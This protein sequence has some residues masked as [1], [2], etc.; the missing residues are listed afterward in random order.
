MSGKYSLQALVIKRLCYI[1]GNMHPTRLLYS[2]LPVLVSGAVAA[3]LDFDQQPLGVVE[4][5][6]GSDFK[7]VADKKAEISKVRARSGK[8]SLRLLGGEKNRVEIHLDK[9]AAANTAISFWAERWTAKASFG[10]SIYAVDAEG[11][12]Q[13][14]Y[15]GGK[16]IKAGGLNTQVSVLIPQATTKLVLE[17]SSPANAGM[18][19][20]DL[21]IAEAVP[22]QIEQL[23]ASQQVVPAL[24]R[25]EHNP[26]AALAVTSSKGSVAA[27]LE[28]LEINLTGTTSLEDI[29]SVSIILAKNA[30]DKPQ[31]VFGTPQAAAQKISFKG[32]LDLPAGTATLWISVKL[33]QTA[34]L[35]HKIDAGFDAITV[36]GKTQQIAQG[37]PQGDQRI[38][39]GVRLRGDSNSKFYRIPGM[40]RT[41]KGSLLATYDVRY[42]HQF[43]LPADIDIG[44]SRSTDQGQNWEDMRIA[45]DM[46][47]DPKFSYDGVGDPCIWVDEKSGRVWIAGL[48]S[49]GKNAFK[50]SKPGLTPEETGQLV[51]AYSDD[52][53]VTWS[54]P[55]NITEQVKNPAWHIILAGPGSGIT[56]QDGTLVWP[57]QYRS[58]KEDNAKPFSTLIYSKDQGKSWKIG[59]GVKIDTTEAQL[60]ETVPG[61][62]MINCRD[63]RGGART[64]YTTKD[65]GASWQVHEATDRKALIESTCQA[66]LIKVEHPKH[67][68]LL[69]FSN[70]ATRK[71]RNHMTL[72]L[73]RDLGE[74]WPQQHDLLY[75]YREGAGY[76]S[77]APIDDTYFGVIYEGQYD[78]Y[79]LRFKYEEFFKSQSSSK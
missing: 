14:I 13:E 22:S 70:P 16:T 28:S 25:K 39:Y 52:D 1:S 36:N 33:K 63:N 67:G 31:A 49:H 61:T 9:P 72:K 17:A 15:Q 59:T 5:I 55:V 45:I 43:D 58:S 75:D 40:V 68:N 78:L 27:K 77:L 66:S 60:V 30:Y 21:Q 2:L 12:Q 73:S 18:L 3:P 44:V 46:G 26:V 79:F 69:I 32:A 10:F 37:S 29:E 11:K 47:N 57:A 19:L 24:I 20:D 34:N 38:G 76:S 56:M 54:K 42:R 65:L 23:L 41:K 48:W 64:I 8:Q 6:A 35:D 50:H 71:G 74:S 7:L 4:S 62:I 53:G 51:L